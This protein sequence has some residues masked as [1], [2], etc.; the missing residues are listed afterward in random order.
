[1]ENLALS[2]SGCNGHKY[3]KI[4]GIDPGSGALVPLFH[5]RRSRW[6]DHF[7]WDENYLR[8]IGL[9]PIGRA[10]VET[11]HLNRPHLINFRRVLVAS[12][13]HPPQ[14]RET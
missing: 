1:M 14:T 2:C 7:E 9:T 5:P 8:I 6:H 12:D 4:T 11:L 10:T 13:R 3:S